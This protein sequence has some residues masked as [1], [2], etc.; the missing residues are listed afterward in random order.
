[1]HTAYGI[2]EIVDLSSNFFITKYYIELV[3]CIYKSDRFNDNDDYDYDYYSLFNFNF[4][5]LDP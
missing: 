3:A 4:N 2:I 5:W 1:M